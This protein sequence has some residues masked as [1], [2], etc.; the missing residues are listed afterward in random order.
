M[1]K[2]FAIVLAC[3]LLLAFGAVPSFAHGYGHVPKIHYPK[4]TPVKATPATPA[5][6]APQGSRGGNGSAAPYVAYGIFGCIMVGQI[7]DT[8]AVKRNR[9]RTRE[10]QDFV[11]ANCLLPF[12][13]GALVRQYWKGKKPQPLLDV[14]DKRHDPI[15]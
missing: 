15:T 4:A 10:D 1:R 7:Y 3:L 12:I 2:L 11:T 8:F 6:P 5:K 13:G 9:K 14:I